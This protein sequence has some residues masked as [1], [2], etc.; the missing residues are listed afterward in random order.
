[1]KF[2]G[3]DGIPHAFQ[4]YLTRVD[5]QSGTV[6]YCI[7]PFKSGV[8][9]S[10]S[11][12]VTAKSP[13]T[14]SALDKQLLGIMMAG[15]PA[16]SASVLG[17]SE[18]EAYYAT[19][20]A[21]EHFLFQHPTTYPNAKGVK[22]SSDDWDKYWSGNAKIIGKAKE[23]YAAGIAA[24]YGGSDT[25]SVTITPIGGDNKMTP[26]VTDAVTGAGTLEITFEITSDKPF[27]KGKL[28]FDDPM[29]KQIVSGNVASKILVNGTEQAFKAGIMGAG[30]YTEGIAVAYAAPKTTVK[31]VLDKLTAESYVP[32]PDEYINAGFTLSTEGNETFAAYMTENTASGYKQDYA[33][34]LPQAVE[35]T[36]MLALTRRD[37]G[38]DDEPGEGGLKILKY[39]KKTHQLTPGAL[40]HVVGLDDSKA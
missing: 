13:A 36:G 30:D 33:V 29:I 24:P 26:V 11:M 32:N 10:G 12:T 6:G 23:I 1:V 18:S 40:F 16:K 34:L 3:D 38:S 2:K 19:L 5:G 25:G 7:S 4:D 31:I 27:T 20:V 14:N 39:N 9:P 22:F 8:Y 17:L 28:V 35:E 21:I 37:S 15:Y